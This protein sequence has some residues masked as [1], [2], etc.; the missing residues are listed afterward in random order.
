MTNKVVLTE[1]GHHKLVQ[2]LDHLKTT[3]RVEAAK[4]LA[5]ARAHGDLRENAEYDAAKEAKRHLETRIAK[6]ELTLSQAKIVSAEEIPEGK[7]LF[8]ATLELKNLDTGDKMK[9]TLVSQEEA[10][11]EQGKIAVTSPIGKGLL[12]KEKNDVAEIQVPAGKVRYKILNIT[13]ELP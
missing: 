2:E 7:A 13:K 5:T 9:F 8:G 6:L 4:D 1:E 12:G 10:D 3:K 11:F